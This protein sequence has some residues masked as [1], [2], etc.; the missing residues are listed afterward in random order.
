MTP[1]TLP[2][3]DRPRGIRDGYTSSVDRI[4]AAVRIAVVVVVTTIS[5]ADAASAAEIVLTTPEGE[6]VV[7]SSWVGE[8]GPLVVL[9]WAS[10]VPRSA[11]TLD[12]LDELSRAARQDGLDL[13]VVAVQEPLED[14]EDGLAGLDLVWLH[15][16]YGELLKEY[17]VVTVPRLVI[18]DRDGRKQRTLPPDPAALRRGGGP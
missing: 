2:V 11:E 17:R 7:W 12:Q 8:R 6:R 1:S 16:R 14:A 10:W 3:P 15:D 9:L 13:V 5:L 18:V 4:A